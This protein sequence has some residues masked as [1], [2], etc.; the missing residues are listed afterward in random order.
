MMKRFILISIFSLALM[1]DVQAAQAPN[2]KVTVESFPKYNLNIKILPEA[3]YLGV[4]GTVQLP[5]TE[6]IRDKLVFA[7]SEMA[8]SLKMEVLQPDASAG[9]IKLERTERPQVTSGLRRWTLLPPHPFPA[10]APVLLRFSYSIENGLDS[11]FYIGPEG[12]FASGVN[13]AWYPEPEDIDQF[14]TRGTGMLQFSVPAGYIT[15]TT[16][17]QR[18]TPEQLAQGAFHFQ[19]DSPVFFSFA[20][21]KYTVF[22]RSGS[23]PISILLLRPRPQQ[24]IERLIEGS[25]RVL[26]ALAEEFG[27]YPYPEFAIIEMPTEQARK[28]GSDGASLSG[29]MLGISSYFDQ[30]FNTAFYGHEIA[31]TWWGNMIQKKGPQGGYMLDEAMANYGSLRAVE[32]LEGAYAAEQY[33]RT[34]YPG[35]Y[36]EYS[37]SVYLSRA[38]A[39]LDHRL[40]DLPLEDGFLSRRMANTKGMLVWD[41][42]SR[43]LGRKVFSRILQGFIRQRAFQRITWEEFLQAIE[44]GAGQNLKWFY[45]QWLERMGVPDWQLTWKQDGAVV[46]G[47]ITQPTPYYQATIEVEAIGSNGRRLVRTVEVNGPHTQFSWRVGLAV[48]TIML[49]PHFLILRWTPEYRAEATALLPYTRGDLKLSQGQVAEAYKEFKDALAQIPERDRYS[50]GFMLEYGL[51]QSLLEQH[52][53]DEAKPYIQAALLRPIRRADILP[54]VYVQLATVAK[55]LNDEVTLWWAVNA[56]INADDAAGGRTGAV[57]QVRT[58]LNTTSK[59]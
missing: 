44:G 58:L 22:R 43:T 35:Y 27:P 47:T 6:G 32:L 38:L 17:T 19:I 46:R 53:E 5:A 1:I 55:R 11:V 51:A 37:G 2:A 54:W 30:E 10:G 57:E 21:G 18:S 25:A 36:S 3:H 26:G 23:L 31:H 59:N 29:F 28:G 20:V 56:V 24:N 13:T 12:S 41:M 15:Y 45:D 49:D 8:T 42:L 7:L 33:R 48:K 9:P 50:L 34:G 39:G 16:G 40:S 52:K 14:R 4:E